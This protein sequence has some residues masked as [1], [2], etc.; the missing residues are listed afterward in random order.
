MAK[1]A[2]NEGVETDLT[3]ALVL[4]DDCYDQV[5][6]TKDRLE[7]LAAFAEKRKPRYT[8]EW[9]EWSSGDYLSIYFAREECLSCS[10]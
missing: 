8:G 9:K 1:R 10:D 2:I 6:N 7:G 3:S 4:E 5:L